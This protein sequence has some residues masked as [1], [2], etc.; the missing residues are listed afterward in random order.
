MM[1][2]KQPPDTHALTN[3]YRYY[4]THVYAPLPH[5][6]VPRTCYASLI[7][8]VEHSRVIQCSDNCP[9]IPYFFH[10]SLHKLSSPNDPIIPSVL[11]KTKKKSVRNDGLRFEP[12]GDEDTI[13]FLKR[14]PAV[15]KDIIKV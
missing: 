5:T 1:P 14:V 12:F 11:L 7:L 3:T 2:S 4:D 13:F 8:F 9:Y 10:S 6:H 15:L